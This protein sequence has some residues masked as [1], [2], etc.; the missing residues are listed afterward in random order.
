MGWYSLN[1]SQ[2]A[3][4]E[5]VS[6]EYAFEGQRSYDILIEGQSYTLFPSCTVNVSSHV[7]TFRPR[8]TVLCDRE[9]GF[10]YFMSAKAKEANVQHKAVVYNCTQSCPQ[11]VLLEQL[12]LETESGA[13]RHDLDFKSIGLSVKNFVRSAA[14]LV[15]KASAE[16]DLE[17]TSP[18]LD[19]SSEETCNPGQA[20]NLASNKP[21]R[22][23]KAVQPYLP[24]DIRAIKKR[25]LASAGRQKAPKNNGKTQKVVVK[26]VQPPNTTARPPATKKAS[27]VKSQLELENQELRKRLK[28][29]EQQL[30]ELKES[31][32]QAQ[33]VLQQSQPP[34]LNTTMLNT[35]TGQLPPATASNPAEDSSV[36]KAM[37]LML[38]AQHM[39]HMAS[40]FSNT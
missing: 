8:A 7:S 13:K 9:S 3:T 23:E 6:I 28:M 39:T 17:Q 36:I 38:A 40:F 14:G 18:P 25:K 34:A 29:M 27:K 12:T 33:P 32:S 16:A 2:E 10:V 1:L 26:S 31:H 21:R 22:S 37:K 35:W 4:F 5:P 11:V 19:K 20:T 30:T 15:T 24:E